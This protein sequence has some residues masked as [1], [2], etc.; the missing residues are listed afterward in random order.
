M[1]HITLRPMRPEDI[2]ELVRITSDTGFFRSDEVAVAREVLVASTKE[3]NGP[4]NYQ[5]YVA[6]D[7][8]SLA[9][10]ICFGPTP[11]TKGTW[12]LYWLAVAP[13]RQGRGIG[14]SLVRRAETEIRRR[15]GRLI[16]LDTSSQEM[17]QP[18]RRFHVSLGYQEVSRIPDFYDEGDA[19]VTFSKNL[20]HQGVQPMKP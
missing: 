5:V 15:G 9:G 1:T 4:D 10:Y 11:L 2:E 6:A 20:S 8:K 18:T 7:A 3:D 13:D 14:H 12:D 17:Y 16:V 19:K